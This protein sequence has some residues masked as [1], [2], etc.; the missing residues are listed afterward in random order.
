MK[1]LGG[2]V[3][4]ARCWRIISTARGANTGL[5]VSRSLGDLDFKEPIRLSSHTTIMPH[6]T[7]LVRTVRA[8]AAHELQASTS[9]ADW[10][11]GWWRAGQMWGVYSCSQATPLSSLLR[12][13]SGMC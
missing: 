2:R 8:Y 5:A 4:F 9:R 11:T 13:A 6:V 1:A 10:C 3:E 7:T 12:M